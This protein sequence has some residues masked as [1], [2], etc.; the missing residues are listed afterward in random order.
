MIYV[1]P[2]IPAPQENGFSEELE[3]EVSKGH[4]LFGIEAQCIARREDCDDYLFQLND[5]SGRYAVVHLTWNVETSPKWPITEM[6]ANLD[7]FKMHRMMPDSED[8]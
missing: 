7:D 2:W 4:P 3:R 8:A 5:K 6:F 1:D